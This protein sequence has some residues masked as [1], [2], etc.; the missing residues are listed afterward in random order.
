MGIPPENKYVMEGYCDTA[1]RFMAILDFYKHSRK[2]EREYF[3]GCF[4]AMYGK[5]FGACF[6]PLLKAKGRAS[7]R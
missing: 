3:D 7:N 4:K 6:A 5:T 2:E 1:E